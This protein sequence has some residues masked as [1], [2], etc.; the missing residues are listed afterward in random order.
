M[1]LLMLAISRRQIAL[2][3]SRFNVS[4]GELKY[5]VQFVAAIREHLN[6]ST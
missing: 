6:I 3:H 1:Q 4:G 2:G 5:A